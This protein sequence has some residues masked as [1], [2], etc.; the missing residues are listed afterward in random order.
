[1]NDFVNLLDTIT[2]SE[3]GSSKR[4]TLLQYC[5]INNISERKMWKKIVEYDLGVNTKNNNFKKIM[6]IRNIYRFQL[7]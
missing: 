4:I 5:K 1:M 6:S 7:C 3:Q 2:N